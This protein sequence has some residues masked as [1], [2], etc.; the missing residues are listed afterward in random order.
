ME[1]TLAQIRTARGRLRAGDPAMETI[2]NAVA[3]CTS[4]A[5]WCCWR[6]LDLTYDAET[7]A[8]GYLS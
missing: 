3:S 1:L 7:A 6:T 5:S 4:V 2:V 8:K